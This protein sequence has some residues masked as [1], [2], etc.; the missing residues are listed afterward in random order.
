MRR[1]L[2]NILFTYKYMYISVYMKIKL[3]DHLQV[4]NGN[5]NKRSM[6]NIAPPRNR[7]FQATNEVWLYKYQH[8]VLAFL[9]YNN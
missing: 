1:G 9:V 8:F 4:A 2:S 7:E 5:E 3:G 6:G